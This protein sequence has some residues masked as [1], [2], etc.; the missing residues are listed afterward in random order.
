MDFDH[1]YL[2]LIE[3][4]KDLSKY[5]IDRLKELQQRAS[6]VYK[7][8]DNLQLVIKGDANSIYGSCGNAYFSMRDYDIATD[9]TVG[10]KHFAIIVDIA[11]NEFFKHWADNPDNLSKIR[12]F[13]PNTKSL[14][15]FTKYKKDTVDDLCVYGDTDSRYVDVEMIY[16][17][18]ESD[19]GIMSLPK[20]N[21]ELSD[22]SVF[23]MD[24]FISKIIR[25]TI[26]EDCE[27]RNARKGYLKM[28]HEVTTRKCSLIK[29]KKYIMTVVYE[30]G[31]LLKKPKLKFKGVELKRGSTSPAM[32]KI[33]TKLV[34]KFLIEEY[35]VED[36]RKECLKIIKYIKQIKKKDNIYLISTVSG[37]KNIEQKDGKYVSD[38]HHIQ[39]Q[40]ALSWMN[41]ITENNLLKDYKFPFEGQK[42]NYYKCEE[43]SS[44]KVIGVPDDVDINDVPNLPEP[45]WNVMIRDSFIKPLLRYIMD[46]NDVSDNDCDNFLMGFTKKI[47]F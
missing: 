44:Y 15:N 29:K 17:L 3:D 38:K 24:N 32:K 23:L 12:E 37:F 27:F 7:E 43:G 10:A 11:I 22:F 40:I 28:A 39:M 25:E 35:S 13:Y 42:M 4:T 45:D 18:I 26:D 41:F 14:I 34:E 21:K 6:E 8:F 31:K 47:S 16:N 1:N 2:Q 30:D 20:D 36:I 9:I 19:N 33:L 46:I 5:N